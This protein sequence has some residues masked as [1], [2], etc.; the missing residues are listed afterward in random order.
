MVSIWATSKHRRALAR[1]PELRSAAT[2]LVF[3]PSSK[4]PSILICP[5]A[6]ST[7][8]RGALPWWVHGV[9]RLVTLWRFDEVRAMTPGAL[10]MNC[11]SRLGTRHMVVGRFSLWQQCRRFIET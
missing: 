4:E 7:R 10:S 11:W 8:W 6:A 2:V 9:E 5:G 1:P 3:E